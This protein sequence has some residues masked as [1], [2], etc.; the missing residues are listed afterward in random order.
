MP[1]R[2]ELSV[3]NLNLNGMMTIEI[4]WSV[5]RISNGIYGSFKPR[6]EENKP[7]NNCDKREN[8]K[9][10]NK[11]LFVSPFHSMLLNRINP[12]TILINGNTSNITVLFSL[13]SFSYD[14]SP[15]QYKYLCI[16]NID[17]TDVKIF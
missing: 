1:L 12:Q 13:F 8:Q 4:S 10:E 15:W 9:I 5:D 2:K 14:Y 7:S 3:L 16:N 6:L 17:Q 11:I